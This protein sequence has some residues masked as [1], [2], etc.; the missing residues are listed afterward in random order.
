MDTDQTPI[1]GKHDDLTQAIIGVF[2]DVYNELGH[3]FLESLYREAMRLALT[4]A[5]LTVESEVP[6]KV[7]F[8]GQII[9]IF[10]ADL[11]VNK[12]VL[13]ELKQCDVLV[14]THEAQTMN[15]L[16]STT[17]EV[18]LL[19]NFGPAPKFKRFIMDNDKKKLIGSISE[20][21]C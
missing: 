21:R 4:E 15:Y 10:R 14:R 20:N 8:R 1:R 12:T 16:K 17:L 3:G 2:F 11:V 9:G 6:I 19:M 13:V 18:A 5:G 7:H